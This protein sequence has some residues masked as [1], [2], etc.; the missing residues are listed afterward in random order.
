VFAIP[1]RFISW[2]G[3]RMVSQQLKGFDRGR[4]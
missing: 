2:V 3:A 1:M 4:F